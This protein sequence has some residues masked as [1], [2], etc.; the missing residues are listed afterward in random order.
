MV[1]EVNHFADDF[2]PRFKVFH[3][4]MRKKVRDVLFISNLYDYIIM[5]EDSRLAERINNEY[6]GL[7]LSQPPRLTWV[8]SAEEALKALDTTAFDLVITMPRLADMDAYS[9]GPKIKNKVPNIPVI[10]L[11]HRALSPDT[12][13]GYRR[14]Q[15]IDRTFV[16]TGNSDLLLAQI[17][18]VEDRLNVEHD[19]ARAGVRVIIFVE[20]SPLYLS[21]L[22][23]ILYRELVGQ[24]QEVLEEKLNE[25]DR[26]LTMRA[27]SKIL[28]AETY[29]EAVDLF[30]QFRPFVLGI[31]SDT[32]IPRAGRLDPEAGLA[33]LSK[34]RT[35]LPDIP[36]LLTSSEPANRE[37]A[38]RIPAAF[39]D[40]NS[41][42]LNT[43]IH[44]FFLTQLGFG[45][46]VFRLPDGREVT[47]AS[48]IRE[49]EKILPTI[50]AESFYYHSSRNDF[51]RWLFARTET[52]L[53]A[54]MRPVTFDDFGGDIEAAR[55]YV[56]SNLQARRQ[57]RQRAVVA[58]YDA[59]AFDPEAFFLKIGKGSLG[60]KAR[61]LAFISVLLGRNPELYAK[62][63]LVEFLIPHTL[64]ITT[65]TFDA[66]TEANNLKYLSK[67]DLPDEEIAELFRRA[68]LPETLAWDLEAYLAKVRYPLAVRSS[69]LLE[70][71]QFRA[72][73]G[74]YRTYMIPNDHLDL[75]T[76]L[77][78]LITAIKLVFAST[79]YLGPKSFAR[80]VGQRTEEERM[81]VIVQEL[82][83]AR[84]GHY[85]YP[86]ISGVAQSHNFYPF[87][88]QRPED[89]IATIALGLGKTV[90]EGSKALRFSPKHPQLLPQFSTVD[91]ILDNAQ[92]HF[93][94]L[95]LD[96]PL[97]ELGVNEESA[98]ARLDVSEAAEEEPARLVASTYVPE[99]HRI[100][101][102]A[103]LPGPKVVTFSQILKYKKFPL[104]DILSDVLEL[105]H[106][107]MGC[108][109]EL[110]F[111]AHL[112]GRG[113]ACKPEFVFLQVR[114]MTARAESMEIEITGQE[115]EQAFCYSSNALGNA[116]RDDLRDIIFIKPNKFDPGKTVQIA[117]EVGRL[118]AELL[119]ENRHYLLIG[120]GRWGSADRWLGIPVAWADISG[121][122]AVVET[123]APTLKAEP[124]QGSHFFH[125][126][127]TL[128]INYFT[129]SDRKPD[130]I[131]LGWLAA[132]PWA[133]ETEFTARVVLDRPF[134][135]K[136]D[137]RR[138]HG[139]IYA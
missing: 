126:V 122:A 19:T 69:G 72:Y 84:H 86:A 113:N 57:R 41:P 1:L 82:I 132:L 80:R 16:W 125:N 23:P 127:T 102:T 131:D 119:K 128:G 93:Y 104:S 71:A 134:T 66:F 15:G 105:L 28:V 98:L 37:R 17:K 133:S 61:G 118:N 33:L 129:V 48:T 89:G 64:V 53:A 139:V 58:D 8:S 77:E 26:L 117:R 46:F 130:H 137:G 6:R 2:D 96:G 101:D 94:A 103:A 60:G 30:E 50:P 76:R 59:A 108:P 120:P 11:T 63:P 40:K 109:V 13:Q 97:R 111:S 124:S 62:Y 45:D 107:G 22:L 20:D 95:R 25:E 27:R 114:P 54:R 68:E 5:E 3:E 136:V 138:S 4:L 81:A 112:C 34:I 121:V 110:E 99:E 65:E 92:R 49:L 85:Y 47:R 44:Q 24:T 115:R 7:N 29:E 14:P 87:A 12:G 79:Y 9:L 100:R 88:R 39:I 36:V 91:D 55:Q 56:I 78:H 135:L 74:L 116:Q 21:S 43:E 51:S 38:A 70:D 123:T 31:I 32:R 10:L 90:V 52:M 83:G 67:T 73:A 75:K 106:E 35:E 42:T 18:S